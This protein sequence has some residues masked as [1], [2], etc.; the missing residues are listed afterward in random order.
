MITSRICIFTETFYPEVGGGETQALQLAKW[1]VS[2]D[3]SVIVITRRSNVS[4]KKIERVGSV[5]VYRLP[6]VGPQHF[7]KWGLV[8]TSLPLLIKLRHQYDLIFVSGFRV[9]GISAVL[10]SRLFRKACILKADSLGEMSG[11]F[12][13]GGL[14][15]LRIHF[16]SL[17]FK[18]FLKFRGNILRRAESFIAISSEVATELENHGVNP[19]II[20]PIPNSVD[21]DRF[22]PVDHAEKLE[23]R[24]KL[25][26]PQQRKIIIYTGRLVSYKGLPLLMQVW[27]E[28]QCKYNNATLLIV[29][30]GG[31]DIHNC[32]KELKKFVKKNGLQDRVSFTGNVENV[33]EYLKSSDIFVLPT[34][35]EAFGIS[36]IEAMACGLPV[37]STFVGGIKDILQ[38]QQN[39][40]VV[41]PGDFKQLYDS[42]DLL[43]N[44]TFLSVKL[45][46][47]GLSTAKERYSTDLVIPRYIELFENTA[48]HRAKT[49]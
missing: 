31:L 44:D 30:S 13:I 38:N 42:L 10:I 9:I 11:A 47:E 48:T 39:G 14:K 20:H 35:N 17:V 6:P 27:Q 34:E 18:S 24:R 40:I 4:F 45:G 25:G 5:I 37:I 21:T 16:S 43:I 15:K 33:H 2:N 1:L 49:H 12:F 46:R 7:K 26:I 29:G 19:A 3:F 32:E 22:F 41:N 8:L 23:L 36:L 28:I